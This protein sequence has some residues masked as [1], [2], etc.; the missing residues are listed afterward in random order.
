MPGAVSCKPCSFTNGI[1]VYLIA[2][3]VAV[4]IYIFACASTIKVSS[5]AMEEIRRSCCRIDSTL[6]L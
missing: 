4:S 3:G 2:P 6:I 1:L 5:L